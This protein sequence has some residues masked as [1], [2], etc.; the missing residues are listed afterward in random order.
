MDPKQILEEAIKRFQGKG[1]EL[2]HFI[3]DIDE[4][5]NQQSFMGNKTPSFNYSK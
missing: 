4:I 1:A 2:G 5:Y 3:G